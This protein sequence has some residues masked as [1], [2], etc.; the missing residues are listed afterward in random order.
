MLSIAKIMF[1]RYNPTRNNRHISNNTSAK[2]LFAPRPFS[3]QTKP[4]INQQQDPFAP[5]PFFIQTKQDEHDGFD[6]LQPGSSVIDDE[7]YQVDGEEY[8]V[9]GGIL[10][11]EE[12]QTSDRN[13]VTTDDGK[14]GEGET[15]GQVE[16]LKIKRGNDRLLEDENDIVRGEDEVRR[17]V[18]SKF[19]GRRRNGTFS[20]RRKRGMGFS[21]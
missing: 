9:E 13:I 4:K 7:E 8:Q 1:Q 19:L 3:A 17:P 11:Q 12:G 15:Q 16:K 10:Q 2:D 6:N 18:L 20:R 21:S 14:R 5:R